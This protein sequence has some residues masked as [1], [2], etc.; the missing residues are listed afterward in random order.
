MAIGCRPVPQPATRMRAGASVIPSRSASGNRSRRKPASEVGA[1]PRRTRCHRGYGLASY[2]ACTAAE[3]SPTISCQRGNRPAKAP[4]LERFLDLADGE[5]AQGG[6]SSARPRSVPPRRACGAVDSKRRSRTRAAVP[7]TPEARAA[8]ITRRKSDD[9]RALFG[10]FLVYVL[11]A[12]SLVRDRGNGRQRERRLRPEAVRDVAQQRT[13]RRCKQALDEIVRDHG[14]LEHALQQR[15]AENTGEPPADAPTTHAHRR[16]G[17]VSARVGFP[18]RR[19][20]WPRGSRSAAPG[21]PGRP[22]GGRALE[23][24]RRERADRRDIA[25]RNS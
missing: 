25:S 8:S 11:G 7:G 5:R 9:T 21:A 20:A 14:G 18:V 19:G 23:A 17:R 13:A 4:L 16:T 1:A 2:W 12:E 15:I 3:T 6:G 22:P 24:A 10:G